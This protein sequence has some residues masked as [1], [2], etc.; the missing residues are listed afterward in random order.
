M[1]MFSQFMICCLLVI[2]PLF[3]I[4]FI[5]YCLCWRSRL[6]MAN[7]Q[8]LFF[9]FSPFQENIFLWT[10]VEL[11][12]MFSHFFILSFVICFILPVCVGEVDWKWKI[13]RKIMGNGKKCT[14]LWQCSFWISFNQLWFDS[15]YLIVVGREV[16]TWSEY[17]IAITWY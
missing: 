4:W 6:K 13:S 3:I 17:I 16:Q 14:F 7:S 8:K 9:F 1:Y 10:L 12:F 2:F 5:N 11:M 15:I